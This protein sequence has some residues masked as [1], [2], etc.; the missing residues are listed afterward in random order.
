MEQYLKDEKKRKE[1]ITLCCQFA[2]CC[3]DYFIN[4]E[5]DREIVLGAMAVFIASCLKYPGSNPI[6]ALVELEGF[7]KM[8]LSMTM[9]LF[10]NK[11]D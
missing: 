3:K 9:I 4:D 8:T 11:E 7:K 5:L 6:R 2:D 10:N 1:I